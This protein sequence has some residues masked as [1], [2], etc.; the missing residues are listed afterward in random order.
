MAKRRTRKPTHVFTPAVVFAPPPPK[1]AA[2]PA[3][4]RCTFCDMLSREPRPLLMVHEDEW[5][6]IMLDDGPLNDRFNDG[7]VCVSKR[8]GVPTPQ[9]IA[10][11]RERAEGTAND[12]LVGPWKLSVSENSHLVMAARCVR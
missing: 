5:C 7:V 3:P 12:R 10:A 1:E 8:H 2:P 9:E 11:L 4:A 6:I